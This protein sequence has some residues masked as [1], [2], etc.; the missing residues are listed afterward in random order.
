M[1][2]YSNVPSQPVGAVVFVKSVLQK[3]KI[4]NFIAGIIAASQNWFEVLIMRKA[5]V[6]TSIDWGAS[7]NNVDG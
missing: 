3:K 6:K 2:S 1:K 7:I 5:R 4:L